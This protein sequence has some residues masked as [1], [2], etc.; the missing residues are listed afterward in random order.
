MSIQEGQLRALASAREQLGATAPN[1]PVGAAVFSVEDEV[2]GIG[3]HLG[4]GRPHA[5]VEALRVCGDRITRAHAMFVT[6]EPMQPP[7]TDPAV[8]PPR[9][10]QQA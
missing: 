4:A 2:L 1:P 6:L 3:T 9:C 7:W 8:Q 5:E 10:C